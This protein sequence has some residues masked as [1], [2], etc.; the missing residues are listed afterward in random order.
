MHE[1]REGEAEVVKP[2]IENDPGHR[3]AEHAGIGEVG[4]PHQS[5]RM[6]LP[7]DHVMLGADLIRAGKLDEAEAAARDLL[8]LYP[9]VPDGWLLSSSPQWLRHRPGALKADEV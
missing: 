9:E 8:V 5:G 6:L 3:D 2:M 4:E 1:A 7:E